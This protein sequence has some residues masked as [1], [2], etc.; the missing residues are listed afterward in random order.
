MG[1]LDFLFGRKRKKTG[2]EFTSEKVTRADEILMQMETE[3]KAEKN[4]AKKKLLRVNYKETED[5]GIVTHYKGKPF[6]G[7]GRHLYENGK[8]KDEI[9]MVEGLK[10]GKAQR[11]SEEGILIGEF[12]YKDD[13]LNGRTKVFN[14]NG[15][16]LKIEGSYVDDKKEGIWKQYND[17]GVLE[18]D[19][20]YKDDVQT[21]RKN[22]P[23]LP[24]FYFAQK[25][26][27]EDNAKRVQ[28]PSAPI[29][30]NKENNEV[31]EEGKYKFLKNASEFES[32][33][34][35][36][37]FL[38]SNEEV[39]IQVNAHEYWDGYFQLSNDKKSDNI[40]HHNL[41]DDGGDTIISIDEKDSKQVISGHYSEGYDL[42]KQTYEDELCE[43]EEGF[44]DKKFIINQLNEFIEED[45]ENASE[46]IEYF[47]D[48]LDVPQSTYDVMELFEATNVRGGAGREEG[49][50]E[51]SWH[52]T[53][54]VRSSGVDLIFC[55]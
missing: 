54:Y 27:D 48:F 28:M 1:L 55:K 25:I 11:F 20:T 38:K 23:D 43:W 36:I 39:K 40:K 46:T 19:F 5:V 52:A 14:E 22:N 12:Q 49:E 35:I 8:S 3:Q 42:K 17:D 24:Q 7:I 9:N 2:L 53:S 34:E 16:V 18:C 6:T 32:I 29:D 4:S 50:D 45:K 10:H 41:Y 37:D 21:D 44:T 26:I 13:K 31:Q 15:I 47:Y 33:K 30:E 51:F